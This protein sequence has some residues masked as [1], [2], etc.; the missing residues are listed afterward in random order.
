M[1]GIRGS[2]SW[3][4]TSFGSARVNQFRPFPIM[5]V[6][7]RSIIFVSKRSWCRS[8]AEVQGFQT[9]PGSFSCDNYRNGSSV[10]I[11]IG[12]YPYLG[13]KFENLKSEPNF[14]THT[15]KTPPG[16]RRMDA[17][18][19][20]HAWIRARLQRTTKWDFARCWD[21]GSISKRRVQFN[22]PVRTRP[23]IFAL[24]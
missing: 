19:K 22:K 8:K 7:M 4:S 10:R 24:K 21:Y 3:N 1:C 18:N 23:I 17:S 15:E 6:R 14:A 9:A 13:S 12:P 20:C 2:E 16:A 11:E 5:C